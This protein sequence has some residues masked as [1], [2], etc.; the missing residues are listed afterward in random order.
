MQRRQA[1]LDRFASVHRGQAAQAS[2]QL[3]WGSVQR[4]HQ[5]APPDH[6]GDLQQVLLLALH[7]TGSTVQECKSCSIAQGCHQALL[8][9]LRRHASWFMPA[10]DGL[11]LVQIHCDS[12]SDKGI[13]RIRIMRE[14]SLADS[15]QLVRLCNASKGPNPQP[16]S[17]QTTSSQPTAA[18]KQVLT[19]TCTHTHT[20]TEP[21]HGPATRA[22]CGSQLRELVLAPTHH[23]SPPDSMLLLEAG[24]RSAAPPFHSHP[25]C[26]QP[27]KAQPA[28]AAAAFRCPTPWHSLRCCRGA[29]AAGEE[30]LDL[31]PWGGRG[32]GG[33]WI[34]QQPELLLLER[35][36]ALALGV[37]EWASRGT[38]VV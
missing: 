3:I 2:A 35:L 37:G 18:R 17:C 21:S 6:S 32:G 13:T 27:Q 28:A 14:P 36:L 25:T 20:G 1:Q 4:I 5:L 29:F 31:L 34:A 10:K 16:Y 23:L 24:A 30:R 8:L 26:R 9:A 15:N 33:A 11:H 38:V 22:A 19:H 12:F 7:R